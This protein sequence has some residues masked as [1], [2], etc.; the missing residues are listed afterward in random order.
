M[1]PGVEDL[2]YARIAREEAVE[3]AQAGR[4]RRSSRQAGLFAT[5]RVFL[6][7][8]FVGSAVS[9]LAEWSVALASLQEALFDA[10]AL[11]PVAVG[12][13]LLAGAALVVGWR[14]RLFAALTIGHLVLALLIASPSLELEL[15]RA[16]GLAHLGL[17][18]AL[19]MVVAHGPGRLSVDRALRRRRRL[20]A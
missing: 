15:G 19:V 20:R 14:A 9:T 2:Q 5:G 18:G 16:V 12:F 8:V 4:D 10:R 7:L 13:Q 1:R 3:R 17:V 6:G 11:L